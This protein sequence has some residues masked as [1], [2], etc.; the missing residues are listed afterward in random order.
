MHFRTCAVRTRHLS[1]CSIKFPRKRRRFLHLF[2]CNG[3]RR[4]NVSPTPPL[5][6]P[7]EYPDLTTHSRRRKVPVLYCAWCLPGTR[8]IWKFEIV[9]KIEPIGGDIVAP[10]LEYEGT[11]PTTSPVRFFSSRTPHV[12]S[13]IAASASFLPYLHAWLSAQPVALMHSQ[14]CHQES[15]SLSSCHATLWS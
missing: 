12:V 14:R 11:T 10:A 8:Y 6:I 7:T 5:P 1:L 13:L 3:S 9:S 2:S 4:G 15:N